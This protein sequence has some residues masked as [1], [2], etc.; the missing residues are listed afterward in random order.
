[1]LKHNRLEGSYLPILKPS[2]TNIANR[3]KRVAAQG[4]E[5][6][7]FNRTNGQS[8]ASMFF[9][10]GKNIEYVRPGSRFRRVHPDDLIET[11]EVESVGTDPYGIPH[12]KFKVSFCRPNRFSYDEGVRMLSLR[13][14]ADRYQERVIA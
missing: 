12:V 1:M 4:T 8:L 9:Q 2:G 10:R 11:A 3:R 13:T 5:M 14:F 7:W 6:G